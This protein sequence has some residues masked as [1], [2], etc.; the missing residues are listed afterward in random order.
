[1]VLPPLYCFL[2]GNILLS[3]PQQVILFKSIALSY[4]DARIR[5]LLVP[6][7]EYQALGLHNHMNSL[8]YQSLIA[9]L[10]HNTSSG[11]LTKLRCQQAIGNGKM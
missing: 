11:S 5:I 2:D 6:W 9:L 8:F 10:Y 4:D 3:L 1:M 7:P